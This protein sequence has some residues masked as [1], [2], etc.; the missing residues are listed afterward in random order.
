MT[1]QNVIP[2]LFWNLFLCHAAIFSLAVRPSLVFSI[3]FAIAQSFPCLWQ[4]EA[5]QSHLLSLSCHS[6]LVSAS[7]L[8]LFFVFIFFGGVLRGCLPTPSNWRP[9][10][11]FRVTMGGVKQDLAENS[12]GKEQN[13]N[14][15]RTERQYLILNPKSYIQHSTF[16]IHHSTSLILYPKS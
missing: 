3:S 14:P 7:P 9:W 1:K 6:E 13:D 16:I 2:G 10:N 4:V 15:T 11:K 8:L 12:Q 5:K